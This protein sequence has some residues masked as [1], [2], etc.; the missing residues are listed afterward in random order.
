MNSF[1]GGQSGRTYHIVKR[2]KSIEEMTYAFSGGGSYTEVNYGQYVLISTFNKNDDE[3]GLLFRRGFDYDDNV[4][5]SLKPQREDTVKNDQG[6][7]IINPE[8]QQL[9]K[10]YYDNVYDQNDNFIGIRFN[11]ERYQTD[12]DIYF[13]HVGNGAIYIGRIVGADGKAPDI[14]LEKWI[15]DYESLSPKRRRNSYAYL[16]SVSDA[17][18][19]EGR[20]NNSPIYNNTIQAATFSELDV[21]GNV[22]EVKLALK[23]PKP[24]FIVSAQSVDAYGDTI[25]SHTDEAS[26]QTDSY[27]EAD[28]EQEQEEQNTNLKINVI[29]ENNDPNGKVIGY[30]NLIRQHSKTGKD[31]HPFYHN[32]DIAIP[33]GIHGND[34]VGIKTKRAILNGED[35]APSNQE[36]DYFWYN[37]GD[38]DSQ[39]NIVNR[40]DEY[41]TFDIKDYN[42]QENG[43]ITEDQGKLPFRVIKNIVSHFNEDR[44]INVNIENIIDPI[45]KEETEI[46]TIIPIT[47]ID[48]AD[49]VPGA[50]YRISKEEHIYAI[51][52]KSGQFGENDLDN[53]QP[54]EVV[55]SDTHAN[56]RCIQI[57]SFAPQSLT[58]NYK[59]G[60]S[61]TPISTRFLDYLYLDYQGN[62]FAK[63]ADGTTSSLGYVDRIRQITQNDGKFI[64]SFIS[65]GANTDQVFYV[66]SIVDMQRIGDQ[67]Y[68]LY[69][70]DDF[71]KNYAASHQFNE[72]YRYLSYSGLNPQS[73]FAQ[74]LSPE[75][76]DD[77]NYHPN[78]FV[79]IKLKSSIQGGYHI[80][81]QFDYENIIWIAQKD[82][83]FYNIKYIGELADIGEGLR[84]LI[85]EDDPE[86]I[87]SSKHYS[88]RT[89]D[90]KAL[91]QDQI[92]NIYKEGY[93]INIINPI[94]IS[95]EEIENNVEFFAYNFNHSQDKVTSVLNRQKINDYFDFQLTKIEHDNPQHY[96]EE[97]NYILIT[98]LKNYIN[99][100]DENSGE[101]KYD[102]YSNW[103]TLQQINETSISLSRV[104]IIDDESNENPNQP[105]NMNN[106]RLN[107]NGIWFVT[108]SG[109]DE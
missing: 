105:K 44:M 71:R 14:G 13:S 42:K 51:C 48:P 69:A 109:H 95:N 57:N 39:K 96:Q 98:L 29:R 68:L 34:V 6:Q 49:V 66:N 41:I 85:A 38:K 90:I 99:E 58:I 87:N 88:G 94:S 91:S 23:I 75:Q 64:I 25:R 104:Y 59:A 89:E 17:N 8:T 52:T 72:D 19:Y 97:Q 37:E 24:T 28:P 61:E 15:E 4:S 106:I 103:Y 63:Y 81:G 11:E 32:Y 40:Y 107:D 31:I 70:D 54:G 46:E 27:I 77:Y 62:L 86:D 50:L 73:R 101:Y 43:N 5:L 100:I 7:D 80:Q 10:K 9:Q 78:Q 21:D 76:Q 108:F 93:I 56:W 83:P 22:K 47:E 84:N 26:G 92:D 45:T 3:N 82:S 16:E 36:I 65:G 60:E 53:I 74:T 55:Q 35:S 18:G 2:Y 79:Y 12:L 67:V 102:I 1:Y 30:S 20:E 33:K